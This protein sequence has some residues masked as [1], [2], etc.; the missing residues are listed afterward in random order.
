MDISYL[1]VDG[2]LHDD[3]YVGVHLIR[4]LFLMTRYPY[5]LNVAVESCTNKQPYPSTACNWGC[6]SVPCSTFISLKF[7]I[8]P[9]LSADYPSIPSVVLVL[10]PYLFSFL[11]NSHRLNL[12][13]EVEASCFG[14]LL[15]R[16]V[17][18]CSQI[19][20][21]APHIYVVPF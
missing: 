21:D 5:S 16:S 8:I 2:I 15:V 18:L 11:H 10:F 19:C 14:W 4:H 3:G 6:S 17:L 13:L 9:R 12:A 1:F 20:C 7:S